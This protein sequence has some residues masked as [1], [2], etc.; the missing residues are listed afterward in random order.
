MPHRPRNRTRS[1]FPPGTG[2]DC[3]KKLP[4]PFVNAEFECP[5]D[6]GDGSSCFASC[7]DGFE[8]ATTAQRF[9]FKCLATGEWQGT[10]RCNCQ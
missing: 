10:V 4:T 1:R 2:I 3:G 6:T 7:G 8:S 5:G 9:E